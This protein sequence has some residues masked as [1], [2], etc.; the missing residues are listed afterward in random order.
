M[1]THH[2]KLVMSHAQSTVLFKPQVPMPVPRRYRMQP[3]PYTAMRLEMVI[4]IFQPKGAGPMMGP[5]TSSVM[6]L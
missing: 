4:M 1:P 6:S 3:T 5:T 2:T